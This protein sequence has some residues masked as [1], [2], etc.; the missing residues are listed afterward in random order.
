VKNACLDAATDELAAVGIRSTTVVHLG[1]GHTQVRWRYN[2]SEERFVNLA[3][4]PSDFRAPRNVRAEVRRL[5]K[6][7]GLITDKAK[8]MAPV[9]KPGHRWA[10]AEGRIGLLEETIKR[11]EE[12]H[13]T[14]SA[15]VETLVTELQAQRV[16][17]GENVDLLA[18]ETKELRQFF[19]DLEAR[20]VALVKQSAVTNTAVAE[21]VV[22]RKA[23]GA[24][25]RSRSKAMVKGRSRRC[26]SSTRRKARK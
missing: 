24:N 18:L 2:G 9:V 25:K 23:E 15:R 26:R 8:V 14:T 20:V 19:T 21:T 7:D 22:P 16:D 1:S 17:I 12:S 6:E 3:S 4:T 11:L 13:N 5:L 10:A